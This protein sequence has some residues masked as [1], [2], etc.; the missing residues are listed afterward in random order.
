[1][2]SQEYIKN[3]LR[4]EPKTYRFNGVGDLTPRLEHAIYGIVTESG[5]LM[6]SLKRVKIYGAKLD[7]VNLIEEA[8]D[9]L[10]YFAILCDEL[11]ITFEDIWDKNIVKLRARFPK[12]YKKQE[13]L[14][15]NLKKE[16]KIL[17]K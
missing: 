11:G 15:R 8:G 6:S 2:T 10:W 9:C 14:N 3:A 5:E 4:T 1:M 16:R 13:A 17:E 7:K 12:K